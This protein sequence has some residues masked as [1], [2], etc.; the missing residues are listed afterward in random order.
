MNSVL[1]RRQ[2]PNNRIICGT[3]KGLS[4]REVDVKQKPEQIK[5]GSAPVRSL[6]NSASAQIA[7]TP[8]LT[9]E[10]ALESYNSRGADAPL[11]FLPRSGRSIR[12]SP[13]IYNSLGPPFDPHEESGRFSRGPDQISSAV[14]GREMHEY[15]EI[16][17]AVGPAGHIRGRGRIR[18][19]NAIGK[20]EPKL[21]REFAQQRGGRNLFSVVCGK[22]DVM[23][24][25]LRMQMRDNIDE[26]CDTSN[27]FSV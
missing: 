18:I 20:G 2:K 24:L 25:K 16:Q 23:K 26:L 22:R 9:S 3:R 7:P 19:T 21:P 13:M 17:T 5:Q 8:P 4:T 12:R 11:V 27:S 6:V 15:A 10:P 14:F 1:C